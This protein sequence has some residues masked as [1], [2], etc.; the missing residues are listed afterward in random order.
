MSESVTPPQVRDF[1]GVPESA[2]GPDYRAHLLEQ[3]KLYVQMADEISKRRD[4]ANTFFLTLNTATI[5]FLGS[6]RALTGLH[7]AWFIA[8]AMGGVTISLVWKR[9]IQ[10]YRDLN[11]AKFLIVHEIEQF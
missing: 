2:Y 10:S 3:Y 8:I 1:L 4:T 11:T 6:I 5:A 9:T 7:P